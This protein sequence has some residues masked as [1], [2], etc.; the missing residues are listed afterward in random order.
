MQLTDGSYERIVRRTLR[1]PPPA[2][3]IDRD[4]LPKSRPRRRPVARSIALEPGTQTW[5]RVNTSLSGPHIAEPQSDSLRRH[6]I[7]ATNG[8]VDVEPNV[9]LTY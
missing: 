3:H 7:S 9:L 6:G 4:L 2:Q 5:V 1:R 8:V